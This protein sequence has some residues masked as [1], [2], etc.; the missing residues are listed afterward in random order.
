VRRHGAEREAENVMSADSTE[1]KHSGLIPFKPGQSGN[2]AG[3]PKGSRNRFA[4]AFVRDFLADWEEHG[5]AVIKQVRDEKPDVYLRTATAILPKVSE[6][7]DDDFDNL[8]SDEIDARLADLEA[9][10]A[11]LA[12][13]KAP[14][15][16]GGK[17]PGEPSSVH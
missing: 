1:G 8:T 11:A 4:E 3:R 17:G 13:G 6:E 5:P 14:A 16:R 2:P 9:R 10:T 12:A 7:P 15:D